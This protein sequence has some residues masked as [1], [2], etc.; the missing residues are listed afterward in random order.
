MPEDQRTPARDEVYW[1]MPGSI[2][3]WRP[4]HA[5]LATKVF[6]EAAAICAE[7]DALFALRAKVNAVEV[8][9]KAPTKAHREEQIRLS[10]TGKVYADEFG[11]MKPELARD[12]MAYVEGAFK[13]L[14][15]KYQ[16]DMVPKLGAHYTYGRKLP[17]GVD[18][19]DVELFQKTVRG[20]LT[21][22]SHRGGA[23]QLD[24]ARLKKHAD[25]YAQQQVDQFVVKL[26]QKLG[27][28]TDVTV[29]WA[30]GHGFECNIVGKL[31]GHEVRVAQSRKFVVNNHGTAFHQWPALIYVD[32]KFTTERAFK[33]LA[34]GA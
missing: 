5:Q 20:Y 33:Q 34:T 27:D 15:Q 6:P 19:A 12:Y 2:T 7:N 18:G 32:G 1:G 21:A 23:A 9:P 16:L 24:R 30:D 25:D 10:A 14:A 17:E 22:D 4:K 3:N 11:K 13:R 26:T 8:A 28:L 31:R 29:T